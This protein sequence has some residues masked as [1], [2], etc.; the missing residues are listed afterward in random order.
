MLLKVK[1][2]A[3]FLVEPVCQVYTE[4]YAVDP[5]SS[6]PY[7]ISEV[8]AEMPPSHTQ[9]PVTPS[10]GL[11]TSRPSIE[12]SVDQPSL[13]PSSAQPPSLSEVPMQ[14]DANTAYATIRRP[15]NDWSLA[16]Q[17][18]IAPFRL[19]ALDPTIESLARDKSEIRTAK[20]SLKMEEYIF[21]QSEHL[22]AWAANKLYRQTG[23]NIPCEDEDYQEWEKKM[24]ENLKD[25]AAVS[26]ASKGDGH[27]GIS[28]VGPVQL[29]ELEKG[30]CLEVPL[31]YIK[32]NAERASTNASTNE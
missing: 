9:D 29:A 7:P 21:A 28:V 32:V 18:T 14:P 11:G 24:Y 17:G 16:M 2:R 13:Q 27:I 10:D 4:R 5:P 3:A 15:K 31:Y 1:T 30:G 26:N 20:A 6:F 23:S 8:T 22:R 12:R 19:F 25:Q